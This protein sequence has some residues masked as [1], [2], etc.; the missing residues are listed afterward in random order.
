MAMIEH[1]SA[2]RGHPLDSD[3]IPIRKL[4]HRVVLDDLQVIQAYDPDT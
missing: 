4:R 2:Q 1:E 3:P